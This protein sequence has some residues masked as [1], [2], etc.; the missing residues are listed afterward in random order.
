MFGAG[1]AQGW[2][3]PKGREQCQQLATAAG[4]NGH[5]AMND[6]L[7]TSRQHPLLLELGV[8]SVVPKQGNNTSF[9]E[10]GVAMLLHV[11]QV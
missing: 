4:N 10:H 9:A 7:C 1:F 8:A 2:H 6:I 3:V 5:L 11:N